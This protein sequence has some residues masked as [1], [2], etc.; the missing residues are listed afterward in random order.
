MLQVPGNLFRGL[1]P[2]AVCYEGQ[3]HVKA[4]EF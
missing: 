4:C 1:H 3:R 2:I